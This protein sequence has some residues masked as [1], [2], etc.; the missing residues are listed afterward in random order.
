MKTPFIYSSVKN[1]EII[2]K[3]KKNKNLE[4]KCE[5]HGLTSKWIYFTKFRK[6]RNIY[7][8]DHRIKKRYSEK[9]INQRKKHGYKDEYL[10]CS[11]CNSEYEKFQSIHS[12][13]KY[14]LRIAKK[15][16]KKD[17]IK[18][19]LSEKDIKKII[20]KQK[21][22]CAYTNIKFKK[23]FN[24]S[25]KNRI[26]NTNFSIDRV[27]SKKG[28]VKSNVELVLLA[29][30]LMKQDLS[31]KNFIK[32]CKRIANP[33]K[34]QGNLKLL[35][36][37]FRKKSIKQ[38]K[39]DKKNFKKG[40]KI[41]CYVH[42]FHRDYIDERPPQGNERGKTINLQFQCQKCYLERKIT[43]KMKSRSQ[44][45]EE[46]KKFKSGNNV[47]CKRHGNHKNYQFIKTAVGGYLRCKI[48]LS[49]SDKKSRKKNIFSNIFTKINSRKNREVKISYE[50]L[51]KLYIKQNGKCALSNTLFDLNVNKPSPDRIDSN[52]DYSFNNLQ[53]TTYLVNRTKWNLDLKTFKFLIKKIDKNFD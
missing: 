44:I 27:N 19:D 46:L 47:F 17:Q 9:E 2:I 14:I 33:P 3:F 35:K 36:Y 4:L 34:T 23:D 1:P 43:L 24:K 10:K 41:L 21:N 11:K 12:P 22:R 15:R 31:K 16:A 37:A 45:D 6:I 40:K 5:K 50:D 28:Y 49:E 25:F 51:I 8:T 7:N 30:N 18:F 39:E 42:S 48:C 32:L 26:K 52:K 38:I 20:I 53:L 13:T 29:I